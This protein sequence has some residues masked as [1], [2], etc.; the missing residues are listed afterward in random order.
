ME[1]KWVRRDFSK[2]SR[3][4][5]SLLKELLVRYKNMP[6]Q[7]IPENYLEQIAAAGPDK[8]EIEAME[9]LKKK[10]NNGKKES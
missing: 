6:V 4:E 7:E 9:E 3:I 5:E 1:K 2:E 10:L 8:G